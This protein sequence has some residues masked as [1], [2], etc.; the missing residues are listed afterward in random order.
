MDLPDNFQTVMSLLSESTYNFQW[1]TSWQ[2]EERT[3]ETEKQAGVRVHWSSYNGRK[4]GEIR[5]MIYVHLSYLCTHAADPSRSIPSHRCSRTVR[6]ACRTYSLP[7]GR[8]N[9]CPLHT[10]RSSVTDPP[11]CNSPSGGLW[12]ENKHRQV[13]VAVGSNYTTWQSRQYT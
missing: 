6:C 10:G 7:S 11:G 12:V 2:I 4:A 8:S 9:R 13:Q 3:F 1:E 5:S